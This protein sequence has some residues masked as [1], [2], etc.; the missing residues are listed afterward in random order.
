MRCRMRFFWHCKKSL[1]E[2]FTLTLTLS[3]KG[4]GI[5]KKEKKSCPQNPSR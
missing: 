5:S 4:E 1:S 2:D 3:L